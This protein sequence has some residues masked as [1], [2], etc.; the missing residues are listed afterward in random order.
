MA[1]VAFILVTIA[2]NLVVGSVVAL[3]RRDNPV[4]WLFLVLAVVLVLD[5]PADE[6]IQY[7]PGWRAPCPAATA[8]AVVSGASWIRGSPW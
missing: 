4:G 5:G 7:A 8:V 2:A 1:T 3:A 6:Y